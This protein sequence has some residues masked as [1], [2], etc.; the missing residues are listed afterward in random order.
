MGKKK[1]KKKEKER[2]GLQMVVDTVYSAEN[3]PKCRICMSD[4]QQTLMMNRPCDCS[5]TMSHVHVHCLLRWM[6][7]SQGSSETCEI[8]SSKY[9]PVVFE[10]IKAVYWRLSLGSIM[11]KFSLAMVIVTL[12]CAFTVYRVFMSDSWDDCL[13]FRVC[14]DVPDQ[15]S[16]FSPERMVV[17][18]GAIIL[19]IVL[20]MI[21]EL[22]RELRYNKRRQMWIDSLMKVAR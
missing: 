21:C 14:H 2:E 9:L 7:S 17:T 13:L 8:C 16:L 18:L 20:I 15:Q 12:W 22:V 19:I 6:S 10:E 1:R 5:G 3:I 4:E 11:M